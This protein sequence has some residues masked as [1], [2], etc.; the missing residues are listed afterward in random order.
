MK[1]LDF[2]LCLNILNILLCLYTYVTLLVCFVIFSIAENSFIPNCLIFLSIL[3]KIFL[4]YVL[5]NTFEKSF[6]NFA[7]SKVAI[8][9]KTNINSRKSTVLLAFAYDAIIILYCLLFFSIK[10]Y[11]FEW[12]YIPVYEIITL[13]GVC[14]FYVALFAIWK[15][16]D[17]LKK[18][19][20]S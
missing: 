18:R 15:I 8:E 4:L 10:E 7:L 13:G 19:K 6:T 9:L 16:Q 11:R 17:K 1:K 3:V 20:F 14:V 5:F 2:Y 12:A